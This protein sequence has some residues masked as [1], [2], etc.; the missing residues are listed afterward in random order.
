MKIAASSICWA[1]DSLEGAVKKAAAAGFTAFEPL[2]F[3]EEIWDLHGDLRK[4]S[5][6]YLKKLCGDHGLTIAGLHL[7]A[8]M[9]PSEERRR[10][11][12]D[13]AKLAIDVAGEVGCK[14]IV[15][16]G[17]DRG[18]VQ[19]FKP[20]LKSL[21]ELAAYVD[22]TDIRIALENHYRNWLQ[23]IEDYEHVFDYVDHPNI[24]MT[25]DTGHFTSAGIDSQKV[26][27]L[28]TA[29]VFHCHIKDHRGTESVAL[30]SGTTNNFGMAAVLKKA[31]F[32]GYLSQELEVHD[33][34]Q[35]DQV[36]ADGIHY[37]RKLIG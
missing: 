31:G 11:L 27:E 5:A 13:Y 21:E 18:T 2:T 32:T 15:E 16:G 22:G 37:M 8:I 3:P 34:S 12:T 30:G 24:G 35:A 20:F 10:V 36:A 29:K 26:A 25:L 4:I 28:F 14:T 1:R 19:P 17:P 23:G 33:E 7:G 6:S 9:T